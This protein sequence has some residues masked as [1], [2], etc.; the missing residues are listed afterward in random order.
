MTKE[1]AGKVDRFYFELGRRIQNARKAQKMTQEALASRIDR[2][3]T[4]VTNI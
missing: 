2:N 1:T 3:R 4:T